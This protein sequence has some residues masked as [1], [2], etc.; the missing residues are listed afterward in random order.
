M[1]IIVAMTVAAGFGALLR[2]FRREA[3]LTQDALAERAG[4]SVEAIRVLEAGRRRHPRPTTVE[5]L[6]AALGL[7]DVDRSR[8]TE[9][10]QRRR[11]VASSDLPADIDDFSG[12]DVE[13]RGLLDALTGPAT[14][15]SLV[16]VAGMGGV[17][18]TA[19]AVHGA[20]QL[21]SVFPDGFLYLNLRGHSSGE[22]AQPLELLQRLLRA[23]GVDEEQVPAEV[24]HAASRYR[25][26]L[27][28]RK[29]LVLLDDAASS[30]QVVSLI[31]GTGGS[32][33]LITSRKQLIGLPG[34]HQLRLDVLSVPD[35]LELLST[36]L[37]ARRVEGE[38]EAALAVARLC[39]H[40]PLA[41]RIAVGYLSGKPGMSLGRLAAEL[42]SSRAKVLSSEGGGV[43]ATVDLSLRALAD[44]PRRIA[45]TAAEVFPIAALLG[46]DDFALRAASAAME[47]P[48]DEVEEALEHLVDVS[49]LET[50]QLHRYRMHALV[51]DVGQEL[52]QA[53]LE[54]SGVAAVHRRVLDHYLA[55]A[56]RIDEHAPPREALG[57]WRKPE[58]SLAAQDL[59]LDAATELLDTDRSNLVAAV[60]TA[61][62]GSLAERLTV[63]RLAAGLSGYGLSQKRWSEWRA[64]LEVAVGVVALD[65]PVAAGVIHFDLGLVYDELAEFELGVA[66]LAQAVSYAPKIGVVAFELAALVNLSHALERANRLAEARAVTKQAQD[67]QPHDGYASW[68]ELVLGMI[69]GKEEDLAG[70]RSAF[71]RSMRLCREFGAEPRTIAMRYR[72]IGESLA[73]AGDYEQ[74]ETAYK[75][76][77]LLHRDQGNEI[78]AAAI[79]EC[80]GTVYVSSGRLD[81]AEAVLSEALPL[82]QGQQQWDCEARIHVALGRRLAALGQ[83]VEAGEAW[84][85]ALGIYVSH[86]ASAADDVRALLA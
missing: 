9:A 41:L 36:I 23:L 74:A 73:E 7:S 42:E 63:V 70:Q 52:A 15:V 81:E 60:R 4:L 86:G 18:K 11:P 66:Q 80:L 75:E 27:A 10:A 57:A 2:A 76:A 56:W 49:L 26:V 45:R 47:Q 59:D 1:T 12:R 46:V 64:V 40:L 30:S 82:A 38:R 24:D 37:G 79:L 78:N 72:T 5:Q 65:D 48:I 44:D 16:S 19:L 21:S 53:A 58:W 3:A 31:P 67:L 28:G 17:G 8:L 29:V 20:R 84:G 32:A 25:S 85:Q 13:M 71:E 22:P 35:A 62:N 68:I 69:A 6:V 34:V 54:Q 55:L 39:G 77:L 43:R 83:T 14:A 61:A 50:P 51:K 33:A